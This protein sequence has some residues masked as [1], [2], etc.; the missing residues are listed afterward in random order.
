M[1]PDVRAVTVAPDLCIVA[2][3]LGVTVKLFLHL[4]HSLDTLLRNFLNQAK[5]Y[6]YKKKMIVASN[7][8]VV[9]LQKLFLLI[10][11]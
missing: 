10:T 9:D 4:F 2:V 11:A 7:Y 5:I 1:F 6:I 8:L 3:N